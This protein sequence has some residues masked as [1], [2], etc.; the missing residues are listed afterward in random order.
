MTLF[1]VRSNCAPK[2]GLNRLANKLGPGTRE[3]I[4]AK[5]VRI[6]SLALESYTKSIV[7]TVFLLEC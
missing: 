6:M 2:E 3:F 5:T 1:I 4:S 7:A